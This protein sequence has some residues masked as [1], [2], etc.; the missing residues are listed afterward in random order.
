MYSITANFFP[1]NKEEMIGY[2][3]AVTGVGLGFGPLMGSALFAAGEYT[4]FGGYNFI[5]YSFGTFLI[6]CSFF[7]KSVFPSS[8]ENF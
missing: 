7:V 6:F 8:I 1:D 3:E 5:F 4:I 2:I